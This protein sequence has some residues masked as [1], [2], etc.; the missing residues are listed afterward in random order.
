MNHDK[1]HRNSN[2]SKR[3]IAGCVELVPTLPD[4]IEFVGGERICGFPIRHLRQFVLRECSRHGNP[5]TTPPEQLILSYPTAW[6]LL[7]GW[8]L[9]LMIGPLINGRIA[10]VHAERHLGPLMI[11]EAW[12]S[13]IYILL[14]NK[15]IFEPEHQ[16][17]WQIL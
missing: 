12:V 2:K 16:S 1:P 13:E 6:M 8:R 3:R 4:Y 10:R 5:K 15:T 14:Q 17:G 9:E 7:V 11:E